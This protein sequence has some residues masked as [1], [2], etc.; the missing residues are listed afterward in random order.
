MLSRNLSRIALRVASRRTVVSPQ[1]AFSHGS[2]HRTNIRSITPRSLASINGDSAIHNNDDNDNHHNN[3]T[4]HLQKPKKGTGFDHFTPRED[5][6]NKPGDKPNEEGTSSDEDKQK[7]PNDEDKNFSKDDKKKSDDFGRNNYNN[8]NQ[9]PNRFENWIPAIVMLLI[10]YYMTQ[11]PGADEVPRGGGSMDREISWHDFLRLLQQQD[12]VKVV[13]TD[14]RQSARVY[15]KSNAKGLSSS[16]SLRTQPQG[17]GSYEEQRRQRAASRDKPDYEEDAEHT[18]FHDQEQEHL[19]G[20]QSA[21]T[22]GS[23]SNVVGG[24]RSTHTPF[25]YRMHIGSVESFERK[26]D[27]AQRALKRNP[28]QDVPVQ[29]L[30]DSV[31][32]SFGLSYPFCVPHNP[33]FLSF[34]FYLH[35]W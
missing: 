31:S 19:E 18:Q 17:F 20:L 13:V 9:D 30:P 29:Y 11:R 21:N 2:F 22:I 25:F 24:S 14:D 15:I 1:Q 5:N 16:S 26:L 7:N 8:N 12:V 32:I 6:N 4:F 3:H 35:C 33:Q 34:L 23:V 27:E 10:T 28:E